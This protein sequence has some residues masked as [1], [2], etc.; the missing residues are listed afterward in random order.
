MMNHLNVGVDKGFS[1][2]NLAVVRADGRLFL[3]AR[4]E[5]FDQRHQHPITDERWLHLLAEPLI[6]FKEL[7]LSFFIGG[8]VESPRSLFDALRGSEFDVQALE[9][10]TDVHVHYGL[11]AMP[12]NAVTVACGSHWNAMYYDQLN[13]VHCFASPRAI[14]DEVPHSFEGITF[15][16]FLLAWWC[17]A[18]DQGRRS[19]LANEILARTGLSAT[20]LREQLEQDPMLDTLSPSRWLALGPLISQHASEEPVVSFL[21]QGVKQLQ[22]LYERFCAQVKPASPPWLVLGG[23]IWSHVLFERVW[24][25]L[26]QVGIPVR[27]SQGNPAWGA[28]RFRRTNPAVQ[29]EPWASRF[30]KREDGA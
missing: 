9:V 13:Y 28:I 20:A 19:P 24:G 4:I 18:R 5:H 17:Q 1:K 25:M 15:A 27:H 21:D 14:W 11:T 23:S 30:T 16:R 12:G 2:T 29:L 22:Q 26:S 3:E 10:F 8:C 6:P 7:P